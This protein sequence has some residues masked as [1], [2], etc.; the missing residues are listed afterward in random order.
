MN[1]TSMINITDS[2]KMVREFLLLLEN[3]LLV[4][5]THAS[6]MM[7]KL[8]KTATSN[9]STTKSVAKPKEIWAVSHQLQ[10]LLRDWSKIY[11][12]L[13]GK[14]QAITQPW[15]SVKLSHL[16]ISPSE[17]Q[18]WENHFLDWVNSKKNSMLTASIINMTK[19]K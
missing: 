1:T 10:L 9:F 11:Q 6:L 2:L 7:Q 13:F 14:Y 12:R 18:V 16:V 17:L 4:L 8:N 19:R 3:T 5:S 15:T